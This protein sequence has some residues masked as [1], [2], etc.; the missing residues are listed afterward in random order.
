MNGALH[1]PPTEA[2]LSPP[3]R[4]MR[5]YVVLAAP[6]ASSAGKAGTERSAEQIAHNVTLCEKKGRTH[7]SAAEQG[8]GWRAEPAGRGSRLRV[9]R[10]LRVDRVSRDWSF[11]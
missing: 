5:H 11:I 1:P 6:R 9:E 3:D 2:A 10:E 4:T 8:G 7:A